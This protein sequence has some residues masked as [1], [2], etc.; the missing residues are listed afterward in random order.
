MPKLRTATI[1]I[2][3][4]D[5]VAEL[6]KAIDSGRVKGKLFAKAIEDF[7]PHELGRLADELLVYYNRKFS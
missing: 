5:R 6:V 3:T 7:S 1:Q 4:N 2:R